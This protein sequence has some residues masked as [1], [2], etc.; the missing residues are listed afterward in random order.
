MCSKSCSQK[1]SVVP[2]GKALRDKKYHAAHRDEVREYQARWWA[3]EQYGE[4]SEV[5]LL[6]QKLVNILRKDYGYDK[7]NSNGLKRN[8]MDNHD[9][10]I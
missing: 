9:A 3:A 5:F 2:N 4:Y 6:N 8:P 7:F 10:V 1:S